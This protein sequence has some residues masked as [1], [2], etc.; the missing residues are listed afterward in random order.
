MDSSVPVPKDRGTGTVK[1][2]EARDRE[3]VT[4]TAV[5]T[6]YKKMGSGHLHEPEHVAQKNHDWQL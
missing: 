3:E 2:Y 1:P 4:G 5:P 6:A